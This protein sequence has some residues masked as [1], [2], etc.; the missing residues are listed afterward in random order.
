MNFEDNPEVRERRYP[1]REFRP[2]RGNR[3]EVQMTKVTCS[4]CGEECEVPFKPVS[5][6]PVYCNDCFAKKDKGSFG[7]PSNK[8][9]NIINEKLDK[10]MKALD[11]E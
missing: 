2:N 4:S 3:R 11:I 7:K 5:T 8:D 6:K 10:I 9:F 1:D